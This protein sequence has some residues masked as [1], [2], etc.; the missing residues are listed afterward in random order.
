MRKN[1]RNLINTGRKISRPRVSG[2]H[3]TEKK[4]EEARTRTHFI[5]RIVESGVTCAGVLRDALSG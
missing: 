3:T 1:A 2:Q 5:G 4:K